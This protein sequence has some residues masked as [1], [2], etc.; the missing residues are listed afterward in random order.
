[1][2]V[3]R[4]KYDALPIEGELI[5]NRDRAIFAPLTDP[6]GPDRIVFKDHFVSIGSRE[7]DDSC[8]S[9]TGYTLDKKNV[10]DDRYIK[11][12]EL[13]FPNCV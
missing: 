12:T 13:F 4:P 8:I 9:I 3:K 1:M 10:G 7:G 5:V 11:R 2:I 6:Y